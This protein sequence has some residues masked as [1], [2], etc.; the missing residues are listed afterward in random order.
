MTGS[1]RKDVDGKTILSLTGHSSMI[2]SVDISDDDQWFLTATCP[3]RQLP[4]TK[5]WD[6][7]G[8]GILSLTGFSGEVG[9]LSGDKAFYTY[10]FSRCAECTTDNDI[11]I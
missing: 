7:K 1:K 11:I 10:R 6:K 5:L 4:E 2:S 9:F 8:N 3:K